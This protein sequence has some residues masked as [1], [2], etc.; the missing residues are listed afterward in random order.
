MQNKT[1]LTILIGSGL[2]VALLAGALVFTFTS[3]ARAQGEATEKMFAGIRVGHGGPG[4]PGD[5]GDGQQALADALGISLEELQAAQQEASDAAIQQAL[6]QGLITQE[7][8][9]AMLLRGHGF[10]GT[11]SFGKDSTI[12]YDALLVGALGISVE[13]LDSARQEVQ[14][15]QL[16]QAV[17]DGTLTQ[18]QADL[19]VA[20][21]ALKEY[22]D[23]DALYAQALGISADQLQ[24]YRDEGLT[25]TQIL[26]KAGKTATEVRDAM[27]S[28]YQAAVAQAVSDGVITQAQAD[29]IQAGGFKGG[30][31][32]F[33]CPPGPGGFERP[34]GG[35]PGEFGAP[36]DAPNPNQN[37]Q[38]PPGT[39]NDL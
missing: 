21:Q 10:R 25:L 38:T 7:Q 4:F 39:G 27:Q 34:R 35:E 9:D 19:I 37:N 2:M 12:D 26:E 20:R 23:P 32:G 3:K 15:A 22:L 30:P 13:E 36:P 28:A 31:G 5:G 16:A 29:Q 11:R 24:S 18:E 33:D 1:K 14:A 17:A 8:A 6:E